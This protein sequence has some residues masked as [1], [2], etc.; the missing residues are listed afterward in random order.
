MGSWS[1]CMRERKRR[2]STTEEWGEGNPCK[3]CPDSDS[4][5]VRIEWPSGTVQ[6][7]RGVAVKQVLTVVEPPLKSPLLESVRVPPKSTVR[8]LEPSLFET[9]TLWVLRICTLVGPGKFGF[10]VA[11]IASVKVQL[12]DDCHVAGVE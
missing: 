5:T 4:A 8:L 12:C 6:E 9:V 11:V 3:H 2:L 7:L 1:Q 10:A